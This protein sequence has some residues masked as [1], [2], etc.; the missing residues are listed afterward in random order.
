MKFSNLIDMEMTDCYFVVSLL[1]LT[2]LLRLGKEVNSIIQTGE[3]FSS[4][5]AEHILVE[6]E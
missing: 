3:L 4:F 5:I 1:F 6:N 2:F